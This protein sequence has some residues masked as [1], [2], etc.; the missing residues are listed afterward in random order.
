[1]KNI[2]NIE[3][4]DI[5]YPIRI[6]FEVTCDS[7]S[8]MFD[9]DTLKERILNYIDDCIDAIDD[10]MRHW[11]DHIHCIDPVKIELYDDNEELIDI[12]EKIYGK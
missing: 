9:K 12:T 3:Q 1:M 11:G 7:H 4:H 8:S 5:D 2:F 10:S 6:T